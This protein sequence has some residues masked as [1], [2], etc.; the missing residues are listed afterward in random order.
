MMVIHVISSVAW[1]GAEAI[2]LTLAI[3]GI[4]TGNTETL[5]AVYVAMGLFGPPFYVPLAIVALVSGIVLSLGTRWGLVSYYWVAIKLV[6]NIAVATG[7][8]FFV[9]TK[10]TDASD[11]ASSVPTS[12]LTASMIG[13]GRFS[14]VGR[15]QHRDGAADNRDRAL[16]LQALGAAPVGAA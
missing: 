5:R 7:G 16:V 6:F 8:T 14:L 1:M 4:N 15:V 3:I 13:D 2:L 11:A 12:S 10:V 9:M